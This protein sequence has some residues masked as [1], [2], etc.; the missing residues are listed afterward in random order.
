MLDK[1]KKAFFDELAMEAS[2]TDPETAKA[3]YIAM[4]RLLLKKL[5]TTGEYHLPDFGKFTIIKYKGKKM[6]N[7]HGEGFVQIEDT[8]TLKFRQDR[9]LQAYI[10]NM[11]N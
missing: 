4:V 10:K 11:R 6:N 8:R 3:I 1:E 2:Y 5:R 7:L 9:K